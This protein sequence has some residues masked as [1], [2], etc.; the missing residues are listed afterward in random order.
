MNIDIHLHS[1]AAGRGFRYRSAN[2]PVPQIQE[3]VVYITKVV[4]EDRIQQRSVEQIIDVPVPQVVEEIVEVISG[5]VQPRRN[6]VAWFYMIL[7]HFIT[8]DSKFNITS[9]KFDI[10]LNRN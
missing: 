2:V 8:F 6:T 9:I 1:F 3:E 10:T 7:W 4:L 5:K